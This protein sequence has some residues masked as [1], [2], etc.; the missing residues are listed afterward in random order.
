MTKRSRDG[1]VVRSDDLD[2]FEKVRRRADRRRKRKEASGFP[3]EPDVQG[4]NELSLA[5]SR[6]R[7]P[8]PGEANRSRLAHEIEE[9]ERDGSEEEYAGPSV[10][11]DDD[12]SPPRLGSTRVREPQTT[13]EPVWGASSTEATGRNSRILWED[14]LRNHLKEEGC[15]SLE[16]I[17][18]AA[19]PNRFNIRPGPRWDGVDRSNGFE[20]RYLAKQTEMAILRMAEA[21]SAMD[22]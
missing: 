22:D 21:R 13:Q 6:K 4:D 17:G 5:P 11:G 8:P 15:G 12:A 2:G 3:R 1:F 20:A 10:L 19:A 7:V 16:A 9:I 14:P 18:S